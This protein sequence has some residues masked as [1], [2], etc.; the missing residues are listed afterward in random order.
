MAQKICVSQSTYS[1][2]EKGHVTMT[3]YYQGAI[4]HCLGISPLQLYD[5]AKPPEDMDTL[6]S[7]LT[8]Q[9]E[10]M[11]EALNKRDMLLEFYKNQLME[12]DKVI[13]T[14]QEVIKEVLNKERQP[15]K[16]ESTE[17]Q[18]IIKLNRPSLKNN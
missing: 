7:G 10:N 6:Q 16:Q 1:R 11:R 18:D 17:Y 12:K 15:L 2:L 3:D 8:A 9:L 4:A 14:L 5:H 13:N